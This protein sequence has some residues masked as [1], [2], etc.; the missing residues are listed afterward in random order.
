MGHKV[1][2]VAGVKSENFTDPGNAIN[3]IWVGN[4]EIISRLPFGDS[5]MA[6]ADWPK[7]GVPKIPWH[8]FIIPM[9]RDIETALNL[10]QGVDWDVIAQTPPHKLI[11]CNGSGCIAHSFTSNFVIT[12]QLINQHPAYL[13]VAVFLM[14]FALAFLG[15]SLSKIPH[16]PEY[17]PT[18]TY[19]ASD[20]HPFALKAYC[21]TVC[22]IA[23]SVIGVVSVGFWIGAHQAYAFKTWDALLLE[24]GYY[25]VLALYMITAT[26]N[27]IK[28][29]REWL[30]VSGAAIHGRRYQSALDDLE[31][32]A[33]KQQTHSLAGQSVT[34]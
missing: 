28:K 2:A 5:D 10:S 33:G 8:N 32:F 7:S 11:C 25:I 19:N 21:S 18:K 16:M 34:V 14:L 20:V 31:H 4:T 6:Q 9:K 15:V 24:Y 1:S 13:V 27:A 17:H 22:T 12:H 29:W 26:W 3:E 30:K 23:G